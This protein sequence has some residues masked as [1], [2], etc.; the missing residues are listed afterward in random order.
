MTES[1]NTLSADKSTWQFVSLPSLGRIFL[2]SVVLVGATA[3]LIISLSSGLAPAHYL[4]AISCITVV[5]LF[6]WNPPAAAVC[7][8][9]GI[10]VAAALGAPGYFGV[11]MALASGLVLY[12]CAAALASTYC[13][14][15]SIW[16]VVS[17]IAFNEIATGGA[18]ATLAMGAVSAL[19]GYSMRSSHSSTLQTA[20]D[21]ARLV[22]EAS[23]AI[24]AERERIADELH[25]IVAHEITVVALQA[26]ALPLAADEKE[27]AEMT[28]AI[29]RASEQALTD[30][31]RMLQVVQNEESTA[32][33]VELSLPPIR[34]ALQNNASQLRA[35]GIEVELAILCATEA[36]QSI[37]TTLVHLARECVTNILRH[38]RHT[39]GVEISIEELENSF[40]MNFVNQIPEEQTP[41]RQSPGGYGLRR[42]AKRVEM[43]GGALHID[44]T[45]DAWRVC[46]TV[47]R[48]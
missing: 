42:M 15:V 44:Q 7:L 32:N 39:M 10:P 37:N 13:I 1:W 29:V 16:V 19:I 26:R 35:F 22:S 23:Q 14:L 33:T 4:P 5:A 18:L 46:V 30:L 2:I 24:R 43:L 34:A 40:V 38:A 12:C 20:A 21:N 28:Q 3:E 11:A 48:K 31:R 27:H 36:S 9:W 25:N 41:P 6:A 47:P 45:P 8:L 17:E